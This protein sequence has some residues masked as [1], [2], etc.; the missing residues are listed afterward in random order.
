M[1][2]APPRSSPSTPSPAS[3]GPGPPPPKSPRTFATNAAREDDGF[4]GQ[5]APRA[6]EGPQSRSPSPRLV[7]PLFAGT[8]ALGA[9]RATPAADSTGGPGDGGKTAPGPAIPLLDADPGAAAL[10]PPDAETEE[11]LARQA[12]AELAAR[13][14]NVSFGIRRPK[15]PVEKAKTQRP[16]SGQ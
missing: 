10:R 12:L 1:A 2:P 7:A 8:L 15:D 6:R 3:S 4:R 16:K 5:L 11:D 13:Y 9:G 14:P